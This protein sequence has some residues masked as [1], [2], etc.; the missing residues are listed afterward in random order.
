[1]NN[2]FVR[3]YRGHNDQKQER[4]HR[5]RDGLSRGEFYRQYAKPGHEEIV[6]MDAYFVFNTTYLDF[7]ESFDKYDVKL[8]QNLEV[9]LGKKITK[10]AFQYLKSCYVG[11]E[12][13]NIFRMIA[14]NKELDRRYYKRFIIR[15]EFNL[16]LIDQL[17]MQKSYSLSQFKEYLEYNYEYYY[18]KDF[19]YYERY[20]ID[21]CKSFAILAHKLEPFYDKFQNM[22][23]KIIKDNQI[24]QKYGKN[25]EEYIIN[26]EVRRREIQKA[27]KR[28]VEEQKRIERFAT[29]KDILV[30]A[31]NAVS[32]SILST[33]ATN[34]SHTNVQEDDISRLKKT[35]ELAIEQKNERITLL[36]QD[37]Q[38][39]KRQRDELREYSVNEFNRGIILLF[40]AMN[41]KK[42]GKIIDYLYTL[43]QSKTCSENLA[44]YLDNLFMT[45]EDMEIEPIMKL[46]EPLKINEQMITKEY[47]LDFTKEQYQSNHCVLK[48]VGWKYKDKII[49]KPT[50]TLKEK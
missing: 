41:D 6:C 20:E 34:Q 9:K 46:T 44:S 24:V 10:E 5:E 18:A 42:Y 43:R 50:L 25:Y 32:D 13:S 27:K 28:Q 33:V 8:K 36:E 1:M 21:Q 12:N 4:G 47:N 16:W 39:F 22:L 14:E 19:F 17:H 35:Y 31:K 23:F 15:L 30:D 11:L 37:I 40:E 48:Y 2:G 7:Q 26:R 45:F 29:P 3:N 38:E 49:E